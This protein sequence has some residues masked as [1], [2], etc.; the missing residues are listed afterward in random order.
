[1]S[2]IAFPLAGLPQLPV[3][4][5]SKVDA[6]AFDLATTAQRE[7]AARRLAA[8]V[9]SDE[10]ADGMCRTEADRA[11][12]AEIGASAAAVARWRAAIRGL[13]P[14]ERLARLLDAP[15][16]GRPRY[17]W[18]GPGAAELW[19][20]WCSD[21]ERTDGPD[22]VE[23]PDGASVWRRLEPV[24]QENGWKLPSVKAFLRREAREIPREQ[25]VRGRQGVMAWLDT[26]SRQ[27]RSVSHLALLEIVNG[28]GRSFDV[29]AELPSG[30]V[31]RPVVWMWQDVRSRYVL[32]WCAGEIESA[33]MVR[34]ALHELITGYGAPGRVVVDN[35]K[36]AS[37]K[38]L[39]GG[40]PGRK[41]WRSTG[42]ELPGLLRLLDI[43]YSATGV[44]QDAGRRGKGRGWAKP[45]E[46]AF[47]DIR[48]QVEGHPRMAGALT[49]RST[50]ARPETH[51]QRAVPW[52][53][54]IRTLS[55]AVQEYNTR[56]GRRME[57]ADGRSIAD[58]W[59]EEWPHTVVRRLSGRQAALLL[60]AAEDPTVQGDGTFSLKAGRAGAL[61]NRYR[62]PELVD[63]SGRKV[64][65][66]FDPHD[67]HRSVQVHDIEGRWI[68]QAEC[69]M[70]VAF[71]DASAGKALE[72][73]RR[74]E[75]RNTEKAIAERGD[76][77]ALRARLDALPPRKAPVLPAPA[78]VLPIA[79]APELPG[80]N[81][82]PRRSRTMAAIVALHREERDE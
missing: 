54:F 5:P 38:W 25:R 20:L 60:L 70:P 12:G 9:R 24:A 14:G 31:G 65:A 46:R 2:V 16:P 82:P 10:L 52:G 1:M 26:Q 75:R 80:S 8:C 21:R 37:A 49:G 7:R 35:T 71:D 27:T 55:D 61:K 30:K 64:V 13:P 29:L 44:V 62:A 77:D 72:R 79:G 42:E 41:R 43:G 34:L 11:A 6:G 4:A 57:V 22:G 50:A 73:M 63:W 74:R 47:R 19:R 76:I 3:E 28:D 78:A 51:R 56:P 69:H 15:R 36:A 48:G 23:G 18:D 17:A 81:A 39:T 59:A 67:L 68:C 45:V 66:R 33:D 32:S 53:D 58:V 40:Q